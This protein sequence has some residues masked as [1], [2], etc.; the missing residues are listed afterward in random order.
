MSK[1]HHFVR[2][3][4]YFVKFGPQKAFN[5]GR[6]PLRS[7]PKAS[8]ACKSDHLG[9]QTPKNDPFLPEKCPFL[10]FS[11]SF[12]PIQRLQN[13]SESDYFDFLKLPKHPRNIANPFPIHLVQFQSIFQSNSMS[14]QSKFES[15]QISSF[16]FRGH[17]F[18]TFRFQTL[19]V[20]I[21]DTQ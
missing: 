5:L 12:L 15:S 19:T 3:F 8:K 13:H 1:K 18:D 9:P 7:I 17:F 20:F 10:P 6:D 2:F 21:S 14:F 16:G 11:D 4:T